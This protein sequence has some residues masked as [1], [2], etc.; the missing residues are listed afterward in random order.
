M[1]IVDTKP[2]GAIFLENQHHW[3]GP[4]TSGRLY[5]SLGLHLPKLSSNFSTDG[6][7]CATNGLPTGWGINSANGHLYQISGHL[8]QISLISVPFFDSEGLMMAEYIGVGI[9]GPCL[10]S[11]VLAQPPPGVSQFLSPLSRVRTHTFHVAFVLATS[12]KSSTRNGPGARTSA[13]R[14]KIPRRES[15]ACETRLSLS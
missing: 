5:H 9:G 3:A 13:K 7:R 8:Y 6:K 12:G 11:R 4:R 10:A 15:L 2:R 1:S 14:V